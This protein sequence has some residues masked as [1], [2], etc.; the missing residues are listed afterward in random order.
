MKTYTMIEIQMELMPEEYR[1][2]LKFMRGQT[3]GVGANG[4]PLVYGH[5]YKKFLREFKRKNDRY[6]KPFKKWKPRSDRQR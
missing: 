2:F 4:E 3:V 5:D 1:E 6:N